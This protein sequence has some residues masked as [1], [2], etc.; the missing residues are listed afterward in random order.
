MKE[1]Q[2]KGYILATV[3]MMLLVLTVIGVA[4][5]RTSTLENIL[6][7]NIRLLEE[8]HEVS[9]SGTKLAAGPIP[10]LI[11]DYDA[12]A[13]ASFVTDV[14]GLS[15]ELRRISLLPNI[16]DGS[17][18]TTSV[19]NGDAAADITF[20]TGNL[21]VSIDIDKAG[22]GD[23]PGGGA[24]NH[25]CYAGVGKCAGKSKLYFY[26]INSESIDATLGT[27]SVTGALYTYVDK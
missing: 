23:M 20:T 3:M 6:A 19:D 10:S 16:I 8:S 22:V 12:G 7:G 13:Y 15:T 5:L 18:V 27:R 2:D 14:N 11:S 9:D 21:N 26:K 24:I 1:R 4:A 25:N 17:G